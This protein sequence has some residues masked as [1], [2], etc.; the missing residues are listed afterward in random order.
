[1]KN[2]KKMKAG[3]VYP[4]SIII[5]LLLFGWHLLDVKDGVFETGDSWL[6]RNYLILAV[7]VFGVVMAGG[8]LLLIKREWKLEQVFL[9][10][11]LG[12]GILYLCVLPP[13]CAP[14]ESSHYISAYKLS[15]QI[16]GKNPTHEDGHVLI[17][18]Q[19]LYFEDLMGVDGRYKTGEKVEPVILG[20]LLDESAY[21]VIHENGLFGGRDNP[22]ALDYDGRPVEGG[23]GWEGESAAVSNLIPVNTTP[24]A[25][26]P[27]ALGITMGRLMG[28]NGTGL[29]FMGR[30]CNLFFYVVLVW[31]AM[32]R[33]PFGKEV[34]FGAAMLP[35][36]LHLTGS[37]SYDVMILALAFYFTACCLDLSYAREHVRVVDVIVMAAVMAV[38]GPCKMVYAVLMGLCLLIPVRKFGG[39]GKWFLSAALVA[40]AFALSMLLVNSRT[41][42][43]YA[44]QTESYVPWAEEAGYSLTYLIHNPVKMIRIFYN[45][46]LYQAEHY[47]LTMIGAYLGNIDEVLN[48][49]YLAAAAFTLCLI[50][51]ALRKPG[52]N[53]P[54]K[55][56]ARVW[57][58][59]LCLGCGAA[60]CLSMLIAWTPMSSAVIA[61]VQGRY[62][63]PVLPVFLLTV[64][65]DWVVLT[66]NGDRAVLYLMCWMNGYV[67]LRL[68]SIVSIRL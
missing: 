19:D 65:N 50:A 20:H 68:F 29:M 5:L 1:M 59:A 18:S 46:V 10:F 55:M 43:V 67:L 53:L 37:M 12:F 64:K 13:L 3:V 49:P 32:K 62:F 30:L 17:R 6:M 41:I 38:L 57:I 61:G 14:D 21:R 54:F 25:Y 24:L 34:V 52:E 48:V 16:M 45:T 44:T 11:G 23:K 40:G 15:N 27:Q 58:W 2:T 39:W 66:K 28:M 42:A 4:A 31:L 51:L 7:C 36:T 26:L 9:V 56:G 33:M 60:V 35:M 63:L 22:G 47:H 8:Y